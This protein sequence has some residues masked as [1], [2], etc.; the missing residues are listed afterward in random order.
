[1]CLQVPGGRVLSLQLPEKD[2]DNTICTALGY[3]ALLVQK[4]GRYLDVPLRYPVAHGASRSY[5]FDMTPSS[6]CEFFT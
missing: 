6:V 1:M 4:L 5:I 3:I 2:T